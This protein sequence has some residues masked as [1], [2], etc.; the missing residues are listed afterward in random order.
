MFRKVDV[1]VFGIVENMSYFIC[2][3]CSGRSEIFAHGGA[4][5][6]AERLNCDFLG[7]IP[8]NIDIRTTSDGGSPIVVSQP[9]SEYAKAYRDISDLVSDKIDQILATR[10]VDAPN[11]VIQ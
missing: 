1:P 6:E 5:V 3:H 9:E 10:E 8:L 2:P 7:E 4:R 11:I